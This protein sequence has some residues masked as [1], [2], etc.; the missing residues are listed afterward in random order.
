MNLI[1]FRFLIGC[2]PNWSRGVS[3]S[4]FTIARFAYYCFWFDLGSVLVER[5]PQFLGLFQDEW[6]KIFTFKRMKGF[7]VNLELNNCKRKI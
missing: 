2:F 6:L 1:G 4:S 3:E 7:V 5:I